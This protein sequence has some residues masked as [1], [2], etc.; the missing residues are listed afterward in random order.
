LF[1]Q[2]TKKFMD[3]LAHLTKDKNIRIKINKHMEHLADRSRE[4]V[5][6]TATALLKYQTE[7]M[8]FC[9]KSYEYF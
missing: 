9:G 6:E 3:C 2:K 8:A 5:D 1:A 7:S 4:C